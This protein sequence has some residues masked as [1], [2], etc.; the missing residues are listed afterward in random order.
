MVGWFG[1][2]EER[3]APIVSSTVVYYLRQANRLYS[4][5]LF[6]FLLHLHRKVFPPSFAAKW[7]YSSL[8]VC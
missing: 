2:G 3:S 6:L 8:L 7:Q 1:A 5:V 4:L